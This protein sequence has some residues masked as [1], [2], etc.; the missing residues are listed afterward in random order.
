MLY[1]TLY[2]CKYK[3]EKNNANKKMNDVFVYRSIF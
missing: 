2:K 3:Y 1:I